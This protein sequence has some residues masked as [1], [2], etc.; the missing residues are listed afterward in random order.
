MLDNYD[1]FVA[2]DIEQSKKLARCPVCCCCGEHI[3][4]EALYDIGGDIYCEDCLN[5]EFRHYTDDYTEE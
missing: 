5:K 1:F 4:D 3:Q 2:H